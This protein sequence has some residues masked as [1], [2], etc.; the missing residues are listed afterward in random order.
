MTVMPPGT[1]GLVPR[2]LQA[3]DDEDA[4]DQARLDLLGHLSEVAATALA[5]AVGSGHADHNDLARMTGW[6]LRPC[7][8]GAVPRMIGCLLTLRKG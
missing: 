2:A 1:A 7:R 5:R 3:L 4:A 6:D 8:H